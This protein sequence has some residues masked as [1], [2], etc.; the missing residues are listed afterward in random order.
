MLTLYVI[1]MCRVYI[2]FRLGRIALVKQ[3][4]FLNIIDRTFGY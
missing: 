3:T 2:K 1:V 4:L